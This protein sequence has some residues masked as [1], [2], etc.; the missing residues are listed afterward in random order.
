MTEL[1]K[2]IEL[3]RAINTMSQLFP[4]DYDYYPKSWFIPTQMQQFCDY[5]Q[6]ESRSQWFIVKPD[7]GKLIRCDYC[8]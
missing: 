7:D 8:M 2:K 4:D 3:T 1:A 6:S 5:F